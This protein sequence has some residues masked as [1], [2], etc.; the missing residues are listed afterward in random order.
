MTDQEMM[1]TVQSIPEKEVIVILRTMEPTAAAAVMLSKT[2]ESWQ[3]YQP[4]DPLK[5]LEKYQEVKNS[6]TNDVSALMQT[7]DLTPARLEQVFISMLV[8]AAP[9]YET[10]HRFKA[11]EKK[12][13]TA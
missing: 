7:A 13:G 8:L 9:M 2:F 6:V 10:L 5:F 4:D 3:K 11:E 1:D 12:K